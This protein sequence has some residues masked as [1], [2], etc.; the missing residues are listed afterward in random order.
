VLI[1]NNSYKIFLK[2]GA[3]CNENIYIQI[4]QLM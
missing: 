4:W 1:Y 2:T 3:K